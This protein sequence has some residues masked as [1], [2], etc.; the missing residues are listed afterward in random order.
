VFAWQTESG[1]PLVVAANRDERLD[2]PARSLTVLRP[3]RPRVLGG[4]DE[5]AGG[6]WLAVNDRG[7]VA[8]LT[9]RPAPGG[10]DLTRRSRGELPLMVAEQRSADE[11]VSHL[12]SV[13]RAGDYNP[14]WLLIGD[15]HVLYYVELTADRSPTVRQLAPGVHVLENVA[16]EDASMKADR[17]RSLVSS[18]RSEQGGL[19][20]ALPRVLADH[21]LPQAT[22][23]SPPK[24]DTAPRRADHAAPRRPDDTA[25]RRAATLAA[26]VH[27]DDYGTRSAALVRVPEDPAHRPQMRV[28]D[29]P[30]CTTP[31]VDAGSFWTD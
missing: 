1:Y 28:A 7:V 19:W 12:L 21:T 24:D 22:A 3:S 25:P 4:L 30:P 6:T 14:G 9:N 31:F 10:R 2:R 29:G 16:L 20:A 8:G 17:V 27:T 5:V 15:R 26:C 11:G 13:V 23:G 18:A